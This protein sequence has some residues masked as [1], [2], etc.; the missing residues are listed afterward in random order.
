MDGASLHFAAVDNNPIGAINDYFKQNFAVNVKNAT[1]LIITSI[2]PVQ[3]E[4]NHR[5]MDI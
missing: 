5:H 1:L 3:H 2:K 4:E